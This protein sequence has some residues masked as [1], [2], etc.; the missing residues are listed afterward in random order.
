MAQ[1]E[2]DAVGGFMAERRPAVL[3]RA[4]R[5][6]AECDVADIETE[7][8]RLRGTLATYEL[9]EAADLIEVLESIARQSHD[10]AAA[11]ET[12]RALTISG[13]ETI[14]ETLGDSS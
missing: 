6:I 1:G 5:A 11:T 3:D 10:D 7:C 13:L 2:T 9:N 4:I 12:A 14:A 8:H